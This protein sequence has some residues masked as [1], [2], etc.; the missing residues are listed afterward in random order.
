MSQA[1][2][3]RS[4]GAGSNVVQLP[5]RS[6]PFQP[7]SAPYPKDILRC[8]RADHPVFINFRIGLGALAMTPERVRDW[9]REDPECV[10][11]AIEWVDC[12]GRGRSWAVFRDDEPGWRLAGQTPAGRSA[13]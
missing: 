8:G 5:V 3:A 2:G 11:N 1:G 9:W 6:T 12:L 4:T 7:N 13:A 10:A